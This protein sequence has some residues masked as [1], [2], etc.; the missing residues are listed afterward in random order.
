MDIFIFVSEQWLLVSALVG[1]VFLYAWNEK[2]RG[3]DALSIHAATR[4]INS[5]DTV[6]IDL[7]DSGEYKQGHI[8]DAINIAH[9]A[10]NGQKQQLEKYR[11]KQI[12]LVDKFG[13]HSGA[14]GKLLKNDGYNIH[15]LEG[16]MTE[17][18]NQNLPLVK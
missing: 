7:R 17:W 5:D 3:G 15:R 13:H 14:V 8:V 1:L 12:L 16:G 10:I 2:R 9:T 4:L 6:V 18:Q 11:Q